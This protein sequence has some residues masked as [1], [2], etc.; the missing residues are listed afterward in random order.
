MAGERTL[1]SLSSYRKRYKKADRAG[2]S[3]LLD[4]FC[5]MTG[6]HRKY[7]ITLLGRPADEGSAPSPRR[8]RGASYGPEVRRALETIWERAGYPWSARLQAM[9]PQWLPWAHRHVRGLTTEVEQALLK[10]SPRQIDRLLAEKKRGKKK[11]LY[12]HTKPGTL[13]KTQ[14]PIR[15]DHWDVTQPG[16]LEIDLVVHCGPSASG[17]YVCSLNLTDIQTGWTQTRAI[18]GKGEAGVVAALEAMRQELPFEVLAIDSDNG[19]EFINHHLVRWCKQHQIAFTRSRPYKKDDNAHIEQKNWTHVR[20]IFGWE[21]YDTSEQ[22]AM[23]NALYHSDLNYMQNLFQ[24]CV[25]LKEKTRV[26]SKLRRHYEAPQ[27]PLDR[28]VAH[29]GE[30]PLPLRVQKLL[31]IRE[32]MDPFSLSSR[33]DHGLKRLMQTTRTPA[34]RAAND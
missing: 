33:I 12:G 31:S 20:K 10:I 18:K 23:M 1:A 34:V 6:Y 13:L 22:C 4:E 27:T 29:Y 2:R 7:A 16:Y 5:V 32:N 3:K 28:L 25:K 8:R 24:P 30:Q 14:I 15:T 9:L 11:R 26:G 17:E 19:S 21:R